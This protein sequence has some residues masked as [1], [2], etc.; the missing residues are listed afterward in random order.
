MSRTAT[1]RRLLD[2]SVSR[3]GAGIALSAVTLSAVFII[4]VYE[5]QLTLVGENA[6]LQSVRTGATLERRVEAAA[7]SAAASG[8]TQALDGLRQE[9]AAL[10]LR[11]LTIFSATGDVLYSLDPGRAPGSSVATVPELRAIH[12]AVTGRE[13]ADRQFAHTLD[14]VRRAIDLQIPF[15]SGSVEGVISAE[16]GIGTIDKALERLRTQAFLLAA[17]VVFFHGLIAAAAYL[18]LVR[19]L[20][21]IVAATQ[22]VAGGKYNL[23]LPRG[24]T[25]E[26]A[27]LVDSFMQMSRS[28]GEMQQSARAA[29]PLTGL[30]GNVEIERH[31]LDRLASGV[32]FA[33]LYCDLDNFK[34]YN[35]CYGFARGDQVILY[36]RD[37]LKKAA[38]TAASPCFVGHQGGD[39]FVVV[40][41]HEDW[42]RVASS[43]VALF[44]HGIGRYYNEADRERGFI[45][46]KDRQDREQRFPLMSVSVAAVSN[47][48][49]RF[50]SFGQIVATVSEVKHLVKG[51]AGSSYAMDRR[52]EP[53]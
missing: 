4:L 29:N 5:N 47:Q 39:D 19:P 52:A 35:D 14:V 24:T 8:W 31:I 18:Q 1:Q 10:D 13:F 38:G 40:C 3:L 27:T 50:D 41:T 12:R 23:V 15:S 36:T 37:C 49:R 26:M 21:G 32:G 51:M 11:K 44:D 33:V 53:G 16:L 46:S 17:L 22:A 20:Y 9:A 48:H 34:A 2:S 42:E 7:A 43:F 6:M 30:P 45:L 28:V 25:Y